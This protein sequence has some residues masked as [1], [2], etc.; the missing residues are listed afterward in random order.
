MQKF[1]NNY[2][3]NYSQNN[4]GN[5]TNKNFFSKDNLTQSQINKKDLHKE[6]NNKY[7]IL[8]NLEEPK[9][10]ENSH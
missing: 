3:S 1:M 10:N 8:K 4:F 5:K 6:I 2:Q 9:Y 7:M